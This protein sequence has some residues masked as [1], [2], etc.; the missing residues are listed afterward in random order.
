MFTGIIQAVGRVAAVAPSEVGLRLSI[1]PGPWDY[2][3]RH[4]HSIA[5]NGVCL[6]YASGAGESDW[7]FDVVRE[8]V[9]RSTL[10]GLRT[11]DSVNLEPALTAE[12]P[13]GGHF[14]QGHV[15][16]IGQVA[17]VRAEPQQWRLTIA[18]EPA[19]MRCVIPKGSVA[20]DGVSL[21]VA[22]VDA[23]KSRFEVAL[24]PTTLGDT[25]LS[26]LQA[27]DSVNLE[28]DMIARTIVHWLE[29][30]AGESGGLTL[31]KLRNA[32]FA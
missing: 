22:A 10:G 9:Q 31:E 18:A 17:A 16:G 24:I 8:T 26:R 15:D 19:V 32:G 23:S 27:G 20:I 14:V 28:T 1:D 13:L 12:T 6:T 3:P 2:R 5:V 11:G 29:H 21:T 30:F 25:T 4:G 7:L